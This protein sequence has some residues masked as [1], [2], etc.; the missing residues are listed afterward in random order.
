MEELASLVSEPLQQ[1]F[2]TDLDRIVLCMKD[3][4]QVL[5]ADL[6]RSMQ[7]AFDAAVYWQTAAKKGPVAYIS[8]SVM[9]SNLL[10]EKY[11]FQIDAYDERFLVDD[12]EAAS[13]WDFSILLQNLDADFD[14]IA[15]TLRQSV[16]RVQEYELWELKKAYHLNYYATATGLLQGLLPL[17]LD[18]LSLDGIDVMPEI[19][20]TIGPYME[21]QMPFY[22]WRRET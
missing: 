17:C 19:Q 8:F 3:N 9:Q 7:K 21:K 10:L 20:F 13:E 2:L 5:N 1:R 6:A 16:I 18:A 4:V 14:V 11:A 12:N 22:Q 15:A